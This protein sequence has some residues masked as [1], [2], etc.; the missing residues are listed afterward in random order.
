MK[1][2]QIL[3]L[4]QQH[5]SRDIT[6][7]KAQMMDSL[8]FRDVYIGSLVTLVKKAYEAG[9]DKGYE[10]GMEAA[11]AMAAEYAKECGE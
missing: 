6:T 8:D 9:L 10:E 1:E 2:A 3:R 4:L 5:I 7:T 11:Q